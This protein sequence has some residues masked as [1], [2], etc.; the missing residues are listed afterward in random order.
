MGY[1][2]SLY[3]GPVFRIK[4]PNSELDKKVLESLGPMRNSYKNQKPPLYRYVD[5]ICEEF[6]REDSL[7]YLQRHV[8]GMGLLGIEH[9]GEQFKKQFGRDLSTDVNDDPEYLILSEDIKKEKEWMIENHT[10]ELSVL[11]QY[12]QIVEVSWAV[13]IDGS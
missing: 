6:S 11:L 9:L 10:V 5:V 4:N 8:G 13:V 1:Y 7:S 3:I 12:F 2:R